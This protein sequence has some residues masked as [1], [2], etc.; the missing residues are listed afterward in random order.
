[1][2]IQDLSSLVQDN[3]KTKQIKLKSHVKFKKKN[4]GQNL[5]QWKPSLFS[6]ANL[7]QIKARSLNSDLE[8]NLKLSSKLILS[9]AKCPCTCPAPR[10]LLYS[11]N[12]H[13]K[14]RP[15]GDNL[16]TLFQDLPIS[17][18]CQQQ[19]CQQ[20][21]NDYLILKCYL[22]PV[23]GLKIIQSFQLQDSSHM[24]TPSKLHWPVAISMSCSLI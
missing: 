4:V 6:N 11:C 8:I 24:L 9:A 5:T 3:L 1:M 10:F 20:L 2:R 15:R 22:T 17:L 7:I 21:D 14:W 16:F 23:I 12:Q 13:W 18:P 19:N